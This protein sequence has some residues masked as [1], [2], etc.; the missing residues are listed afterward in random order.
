MSKVMSFRVM[1]FTVIVVKW[2]D[3]VDGNTYHSVRCVR[4]KDGA[5]V[6]G[7]YQYGYGEHYKQTALYAMAGV[8]WLSKMYSPG[9][10][11]KRKKAGLSPFTVKVYMPTDSWEYERENKYPILWTVSYGLKREC[12]ANG[13]L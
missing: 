11:R 1:K 7:P 10:C 9:E 2:W 5:V 12:V 8:G 3:K 6:V 4:H 13:R